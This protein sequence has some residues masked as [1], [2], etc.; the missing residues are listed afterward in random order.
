MEDGN[1]SGV[2][3]DSGDDPALVGQRD[4]SG[5]LIVVGVVAAMG[6]ASDNLG[7]VVMAAEES[8]VVEIERL[9][10]PWLS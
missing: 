2:A 8:A 5:L 3:A 7:A 1:G 6:P 9:A 4:A 10:G